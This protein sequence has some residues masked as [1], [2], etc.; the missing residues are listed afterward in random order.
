MAEGRKKDFESFK[1][2]SIIERVTDEKTIIDKS[3]QTF[4]HTHKRFL[5]QAVEMAVSAKVCPRRN[6]L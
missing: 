4:A 3:L 1:L 2:N 6:E 5:L